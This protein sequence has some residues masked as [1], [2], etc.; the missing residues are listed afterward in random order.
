MEHNHD[1]GLLDGLTVEWPPLILESFLINRLGL[2]NG[3]CGNLLKAS[4][5]WTGHFTRTNCSHSNYFFH[6]N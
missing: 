3:T 1:R 4:R 6:Y 5:N 2:N